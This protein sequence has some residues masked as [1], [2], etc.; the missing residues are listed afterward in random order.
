M[1]G[2]TIPAHKKMHPVEKTKRNASWLET[3]RWWLERTHKEFKKRGYDP[4]YTFKPY[5]QR[6]RRNKVYIRRAQR[7]WN[8]ANYYYHTRERPYYY[9]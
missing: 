9:P 7:E 4:D 6:I 3:Q 5:R 1:L 2:N 8:K